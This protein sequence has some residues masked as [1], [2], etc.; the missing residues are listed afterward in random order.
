MLF[1]KPFP[2]SRSVACRSTDWLQTCANQS[3]SQI[4][5]LRYQAYRHFLDNYRSILPGQHRA[6]KFSGFSVVFYGTNLIFG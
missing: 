3:L 5:R 1:V 6:G 4:S 2:F